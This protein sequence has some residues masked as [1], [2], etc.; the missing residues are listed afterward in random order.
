M[1]NVQRNF[2][3][4]NILSEAKI[5]DKLDFKKLPYMDNIVNF[6]NN[7]I[8]LIFLNIDR[9]KNHNYLKQDIRSLK[10]III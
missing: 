6:N 10:K 7:N 8:C 1:I 2:F 3:V 5:H 4:E 9:I